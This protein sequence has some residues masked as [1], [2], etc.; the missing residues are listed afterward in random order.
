MSDKRQMPRFNVGDTVILKKSIVSQKKA[1]EFSSSLF[2]NPDMLD[3][4][5]RPMRVCEVQKRERGFICFVAENNWVWHQNWL[6][7]VK[8]A[9]K[10]KFKVGDWVII[11]EEIVNR[12]NASE[13]TSHTVFFHDNMLVWKKN[14]MKIASV[15]PTYRGYKYRVREN[16]CSWA[17]EWLNKVE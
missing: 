12:E 7:L 10:P 8:K 5:A 14:F 16:N 11:K 13:L 3:W 4:T 2:F 6:T 17:E 9:E 1:R 15:H